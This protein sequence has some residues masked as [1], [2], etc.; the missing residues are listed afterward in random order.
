MSGQGDDL[1]S[2]GGKMD[3]VFLDI[4]T[5]VRGQLWKEEE[6]P[7]FLILSREMLFEAVQVNME[8]SRILSF[9]LA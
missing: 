6:R 1:I 4:P 8:F 9:S 7:L 2:V 3:N 5:E